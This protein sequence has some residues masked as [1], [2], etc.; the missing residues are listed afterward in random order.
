M[1]SNRTIFPLRFGRGTQKVTLYAPTS[2]LPYFRLTYRLG[3]K[4]LQRTFSSFEKAKEVAAAI[5]DKLAS[6]E[7]TVAEVT[8]TSPRIFD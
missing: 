8:S 5:A 1:K 4:R 6:G 2:A 3:G 7:V